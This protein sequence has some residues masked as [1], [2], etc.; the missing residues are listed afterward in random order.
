MNYEIVKTFNNNVIL[1]RQEQQEMILVGKGIGFGKKTGDDIAAN[2][3][4]IEKIFHELQSG[5]S[6]NYL[7]MI[8]K[9]KKEII[10]VS[11]EIIARAETILG[12][13]S[14]N[15]HVALIDHITF[16]IDRI[17]MALPIENPFTEEI[18]LLYEEEYE[19]AQLAATLLE[20]RLGVDIGDDEKGFIALHLHSARNNKTIRETMKNT[21][22]FKACTDLIVAEIGDQY[23]NKGHAYQ[24]FIPNLKTTL[25]LCRRKKTIKNPL[26]REVKMKL[27]KSYTIASKIAE[28]IEEEKGLTLSDDMIAYIAI[29]IERIRQYEQ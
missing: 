18:I 28:L 1:A 26:T 13:L 12:L 17:N 4:T 8:P 9:Y 21:R 7:D 29:D 11:E 20:E 23:P 16:A 19:V 25:S 14:P 5:D 10:G 2:P 22:L 15:I 3:E 6:L 27:R 24:S